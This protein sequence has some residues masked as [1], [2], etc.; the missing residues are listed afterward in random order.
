MTTMK[1]VA[2]AAEVS[3][4]T[5]SHVINRTR[6]VSDEL[7][8]RVRQ[9]MHDLNYRPN[10]LARSLRQGITNTIGLVVP[11]NSNPFFAEV[12]RVVETRGFEHGYS[13]ILCNTDGQPDKELTYISML[14]AKQVDGII[15]ISTSGESEF[16][17]LISDQR[18]PVVIADRQLLDC[19][20]DIVL[21]DNY[22]GGRLATEHL[23]SLGHVRIGILTGPS[24]TSPSADR[25]HGHI[26]ALSAAGL[27][28][29]D[30][31]IVRGDFR[32]G[33]VASQTHQL[34]E[35]E[36][37]PTAI[38]ACNDVMAMAAMA[39]IRERGLDVPRDVSVVGFDD[40]PQASF[41][42]P[43]LTT[44]AQPIEELGRVATDLLL[45]RMSE[46]RLGSGERV[47]LDVKLMVRGSSGPKRQSND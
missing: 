11:D 12:A 40:I 4:T 29:D 21:V 33:S 16:V 9:A 10:T 27:A 24:N 2:K 36:Q 46:D 31:L 7:R 22:R 41:T 35:L 37:P 17:G 13:S 18:V 6:Y 3:V 42:W 30:A 32:Y 1:E 34:L 45:Q 5:V 14:L 28:I 39:A 38:F 43:P 19:D 23:L 15:L 8:Q 25:V 26:D 47:M 20:A 44:V